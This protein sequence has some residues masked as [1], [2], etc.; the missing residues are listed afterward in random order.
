M[1]KGDVCGLLISIKQPIIHYTN[2]GLDVSD[3]MKLPGYLKCE[4]RNYHIER[5]YFQAE[6]G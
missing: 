4:I 5:T 2:L 1:N 3:A 6:T